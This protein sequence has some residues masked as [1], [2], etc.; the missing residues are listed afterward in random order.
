MVVNWFDVFIQGIGFVGIGLNI[1]AVQFNKHWQIVL[2][3]TLGTLAFTI[4]YL[5]LKAYT[6]MAMDAIGVFRNI[7]FIFV[8]KKEKTTLPWII[9]FSSLTLVLGIISFEG[10]ISLL[11]IVAKLLSCISYGLKSPKMIR[12]LNLP[13]S[14][15]WLVYNA[16]HFTLAG[17]LNEVFV[18]ISIIIAEIRVYYKEQKQKKENKLNDI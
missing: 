16:L 6:G 4:Q 8:V 15:C 18:I 2:L 10:A 11:V 12:M 7:L 17:V 5:F 13:S 14:T 1:W 3:K 9:L